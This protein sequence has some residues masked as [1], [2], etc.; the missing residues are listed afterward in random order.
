MNM[1]LVDM[2][3][4]TGCKQCALACSLTKE[5]LFDPHRS[6]IKILKKE[7][8]AL[9]IQMLCEQ[10]EAHPCIDA[11]SEGALTR[12]EKTGIISVNIESCNE[13]GS[14]VDACPYHGIRLHPETN[15]PLIC[16]L[17]GGNPY[18][19]PHCVP[20]ALSWIDEVDNAAKKKLRS[21]RMAMYRDVE[22]G[23]AK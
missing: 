1:L 16:D 4:C 13:C 17:C 5:D 9:G 20:G 7:D 18:C 2:K 11:C 21:A 3:K 23:V 6:R 12:N 10:C 14:C 22:K 15:K 19:A 8:I